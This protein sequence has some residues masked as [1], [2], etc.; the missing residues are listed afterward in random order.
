MCLWHFQF[1]CDVTT[2]RWHCG[3]QLYIHLLFH[4]L[5]PKRKRLCWLK[6]SD[7]YIRQLFPYRFQL[8][9]TEDIVR[10]HLGA[11][12]RLT[13]VHSAYGQHHFTT[14][15]TNRCLEAGRSCGPGGWEMGSGS[16]LLAQISCDLGWI[17]SSFFS[18]RFPSLRIIHISLPVFCLPLL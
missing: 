12:C 15:Q 7:K 4:T 1:G 9:L 6:F 17:A 3:S 5:L 8:Q 16:C 2:G 10:L 18:Y 14:W 13:F 11:I